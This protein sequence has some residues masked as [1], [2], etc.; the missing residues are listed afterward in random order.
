MEGRQ[1]QLVWASELYYRRGLSQQK[2]S[3]IM[4]VS[5]PTVSRLLE[6]ARRC[7][8]VEI[9]VHAPLEQNSPLSEQL[10]QSLSLTDAMVLCGRYDHDPALRR[11]AQ[12]AGQIFLSVLESGMTVGLSWGRALRQ[13]CELLPAQSHVFDIRVVQTIGCLG[14]GNPHLDGLELSL[15]LAKKL[16]G[17]FCNVYAPVYVDSPLVQSYLLQEPSVALAIR[18]SA[19]ADI[20]L[21]GIGSLRDPEGSLCKAGYFPAEERHALLASGAAAVLQGRLLDAQGQELEIPGRYVIGA[22]LS[23]LR[24]ARTRIGINAGT[25]RAPETLAAIRSGCINLLVCDEVLAEELLDLNNSRS[26]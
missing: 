22:G 15:M 24:H 2:I 17:T 8:V 11:C 25:G 4:G 16:N 1:A 9:T 12:A 18:Q 20:L 10:R 6:E 3:E 23:D 14:T 5:R 7:G 26:S 19:Q 21:T 13:F